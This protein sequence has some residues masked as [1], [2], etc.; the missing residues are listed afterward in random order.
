ML[1]RLISILAFVAAVSALSINVPD[2]PTSSGEVT[3]TWDATSSD[4]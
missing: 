1:T 2:D 4:E 3:I